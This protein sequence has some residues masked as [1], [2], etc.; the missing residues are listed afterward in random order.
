MT[1]DRPN[2]AYF[3]QFSTAGEEQTRHIEQRLKALEERLDT[4]VEPKVAMSEKRLDFVV[5]CI[6]R[7]FN[8]LFVHKTQAGDQANGMGRNVTIEFC[9]D[10]A[11]NFGQGGGGRGS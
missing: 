3:S 11:P 9:K 10:K 8:S 5:E 4:I 6:R 2:I 1:T 7:F